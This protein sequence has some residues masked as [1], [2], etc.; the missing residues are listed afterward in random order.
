MP[1]PDGAVQANGLS[2]EFFGSPCSPFGPSTG[3]VSARTTTTRTTTRRTN[4]ANGGMRWKSQDGKE[5]T[6]LHFPNVVA[7]A[8]AALPKWATGQEKMCGKAHNTGGEEGTA[9]GAGRKGRDKAKAR[10]STTHWSRLA[11]PGNSTPSAPPG[12]VAH[13]A[14]RPILQ[15][16]LR[17][18][19]THRFLP[20]LSPIQTSLSN[21]RRD[22]P[23][24]QWPLRGWRR[25]RRSQ[26]QPVQ[27]GSPAHTRE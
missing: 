8:V 22:F 16:A 14:L 9:T 17:K 10:K 6:L 11:P 3:D 19:H 1:I 5:G 26:M 18:A 27:D 2:W 23:N 24:F 7:I 21:S 25:P 13:L 12:P 20:R 15:E 4:L